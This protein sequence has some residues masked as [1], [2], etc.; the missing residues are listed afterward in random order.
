[1]STEALELPGLRQRSSA[2]RDTLDRHYT[3]QRLADRIVDLL[4]DLGH[5]EEGWIVEPSVGGGAFVRALRRHE[6][7]GGYPRRPIIGVDKDPAAPGL[8]LCDRFLRGDAAALV[9]SI[10]VHLGE[11]PRT[12][13]GNVPFG[14]PRLK[15][16]RAP[17]D[18]PYIGAHHVLACLEAA[19]VVATILPYAWLAVDPLGPLL[20]DRHPPVEVH[21]IA[22]RPW[23]VTRDAALYVFER[24]FTGETAIRRRRI[25]WE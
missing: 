5:L 3:P 10:H 16:G 14:G 19:S 24:D 4:I 20:F 7:G 23:K 9:P 12:A 21:R 6:R 25:E 1:M 17:G 11:S 8:S 18:P 2:A 22:G 15:Q 13:L